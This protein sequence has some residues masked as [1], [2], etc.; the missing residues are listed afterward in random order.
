MMCGAGSGFQG[1]V[2][3]KLPPESYSNIS[4]PS[5]LRIQVS[6]PSKVSYIL[7]CGVRRKLPL[8]PYSNISR[9]S[10]P[11]IQESHLG[12]LDNDVCAGCMVKA[13]YCCV[14]FAASYPQNPTAI[15]AGQVNSEFKYPTYQ[16]LDI[17]VWVGWTYSSIHAGGTA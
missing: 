9:A 14:G 2:C 1:G 4:R 13:I 7:L 17:N 12:K 3:R 16:K 8:N 10:Q 6:H 11:R 15:I 5:Q